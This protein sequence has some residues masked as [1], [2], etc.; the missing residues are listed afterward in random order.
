MET[1]FT[2]SE[3]AH[4]TLQTADGEAAARI[5]VYDALRA[6]AAAEQ[7]PNE[8]YRWAKVLD[9]LA[10][11]LGIERDRLAENMAIDFHE[12]VVTLRDK[13]AAE[14]KKKLA[15]IAC[16]PEPIPASQATTDPGP[17]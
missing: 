14:R 1:T 3:P 10:G 17:T 4:V 2:L 7:Q 11:K 5:D 16:L 15:A 12:L 6:C 13:L 8:A 9:Y